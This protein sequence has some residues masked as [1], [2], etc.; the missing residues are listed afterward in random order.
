MVNTRD[1][2]V[3]AIDTLTGDC[4]LSGHEDGYSRLWDLR[5][6][7]NRPVN[8]FKHHSTI[9]S[10]LQANPH[11]NYLF[12]SAGYDAHL[13]VNDIRSQYPIWTHKSQNKL[14][15]LQWTSPQ[16]LVFAG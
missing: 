4:V 12:A 3:L 7:V 11:N 6:N 14:F 15:T 1:S 8:S 10:S 16:H 5:V 2:P 13:N 9:V